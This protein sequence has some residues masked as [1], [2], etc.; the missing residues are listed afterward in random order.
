MSKYLIYAKESC[1]YCNKLLKY[2]KENDKKF[3]YVLN[4][5]LE[6]E[7]HTTMEKYN[8]RTVP[9]VI[10]IRDKE[11]CLIGGCDDTIKYFERKRTGRDIISTSRDN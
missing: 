8:W 3:I 10:E 1:P 5:G 7:L 11:E 6:S 2:M 4:Y 9:I